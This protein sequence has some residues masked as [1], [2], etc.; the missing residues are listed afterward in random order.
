MFICYANFR[1]I[2]YEQQRR[3]AKIICIHEQKSL[4]RRPPYRYGGLRSKRKVD[5]YAISS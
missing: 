1:A 3:E 2:F 4:L 5:F